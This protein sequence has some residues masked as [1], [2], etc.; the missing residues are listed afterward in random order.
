MSEC[1][2]LIFLQK[3]EKDYKSDFRSPA[4]ERGEE[5]EAAELVVDHGEVGQG[6]PMIHDALHRDINWLLCVIWGKGDGGRANPMTLALAWRRASSDNRV[7]V[8]EVVEMR[9]VDDLEGMGNVS[10]RS[11]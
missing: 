4:A 1:G 6:E 7:V 9:Q 5:E 10:R 11:L 3:N 8:Y 2:L